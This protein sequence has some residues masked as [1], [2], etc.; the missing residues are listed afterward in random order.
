MHCIHSLL[1][2]NLTRRCWCPLDLLFACKSWRNSSCN[3]MFALSPQFEEP[4]YISKPH[5]PASCLHF[6]HLRR[7]DYVLRLVISRVESLEDSCS[8]SLRLWL[9]SRFPSW[10][11]CPFTAIRK[12]STRL[13]TTQPNVMSAR[14]KS[15][16][17]QI[18][19]CL[20]SLQIDIVITWSLRR[21][22]R[23]QMS[24]RLHAQFFTL[25]I[26]VSAFA[27]AKTCRCELWS[28]A[29]FSLN[30]SANK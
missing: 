5:N 8:S 21:W 6:S 1:V 26:L 10:F 9:A 19:C 25:L 18:M 17:E 24:S 27:S 3:C 15:F 12:A 14:L 11:M 13:K 20:S 30:C 7:S 23:A 16:K 4:R 29:L 28:V 2:Q 22:L